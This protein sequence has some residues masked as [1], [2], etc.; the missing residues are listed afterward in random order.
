MNKLGEY[1]KIELFVYSSS[2]YLFFFLLTHKRPL[3][4]ANYVTVIH[5]W[6]WFHYGSH[7]GQQKD[8]TF[9]SQTFTHLIL[10]IVVLVVT[11]PL[12]LS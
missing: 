9:L 1:E 6:F 10:A 11:Q 3:V 2:M 4:F 12:H 5:D 8:H 7:N